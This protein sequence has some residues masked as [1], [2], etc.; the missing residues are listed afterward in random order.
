MPWIINNQILNENTPNRDNFKII[1]EFIQKLLANISCSLNVSLLMLNWINEIIDLIP[2]EHQNFFQNKLFTKLFNSLI[3]LGYSIEENVCTECSNI[4]IKILIKSQ[5]DLNISVLK[6]ILDLS[7]HY[8]MNSN[9]IIKQNFEKLI[10]KIPINILGINNIDLN[11]LN[12]NDF[13]IYSLLSRHLFI[14]QSSADSALSINN[15]RNIMNFLVIEIDSN[16]FN[17]NLKWIKNL[18]YSSLRNIEN[19]YINNEN[20]KQ[21]QYIDLLNNL[22]S[23]NETLLWNWILNELAKF[24]VQYKLK[25]PFG[26]AQDTFFAIESKFFFIY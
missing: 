11:D 1:I 21:L 9:N 23:N 6:R 8:Q 18:F 19:N 16:E 5:Y 14:T 13:T 24:C 26:K 7:K 2:I 3:T 4:L 17:N 22:N 20:N 12:E 25:S 15:F 10:D